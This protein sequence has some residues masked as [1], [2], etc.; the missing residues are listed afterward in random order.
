[1]FDLL[2]STLS[3]TA[4]LCVLDFAENGTIIVQREQFARYFMKVGFTI[5]PIVTLVD[6]RM[7]GDDEFEPGERAALL[8]M[9]RKENRTPRLRISH[10]IVSDDLTHDDSAVQH[11]LKLH[12][13]MMESIRKSTEAKW[14]T[15]YFF[16]D[17]CKAQFKNVTMFL[18]LSM[19]MDMFLMTVVWCFF[20]SCHVSP[21]PSLPLPL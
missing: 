17:G 7:L 2:C 6:M 8:E 18:Y 15:S 13:D 16:S 4:F 3:L 19:W 12:M 1:M 11:Y 9:F 21:P 14:E 20:C 10:L 5:F